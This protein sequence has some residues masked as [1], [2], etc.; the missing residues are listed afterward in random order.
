M[1]ARFLGLGFFADEETLLEPFAGGLVVELQCRPGHANRKDENAGSDKNM[2][3]QRIVGMTL[4]PVHLQINKRIVGDVHQA[5][6]RR[7]V[8]SLPAPATTMRGKS[9]ITANVP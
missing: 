1:L 8:V 3:R 6:V 7:S 9:A 4:R 2:Y 5:V